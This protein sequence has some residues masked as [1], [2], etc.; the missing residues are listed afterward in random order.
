[1]FLNKLEFNEFSENFF[2]G[3]CSAGGGCG[4]DFVFFDCNLEVRD[5]DGP[6]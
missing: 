1:L 6:N 2:E 3:V 4:W 5:V